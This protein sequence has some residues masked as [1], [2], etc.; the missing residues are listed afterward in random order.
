MI[1]RV[2]FIKDKI[3]VEYAADRMSAIS[4]DEMDKWTKEAF[5]DKLPPLR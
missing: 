3:D 4:D 5:A 1:P 2:I